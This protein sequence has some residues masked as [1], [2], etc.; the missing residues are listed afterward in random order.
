MA[1]IRLQSVTI[2]NLRS[3]FHE[4]FTLSDF[5]ALIGYNNAGKTNIL[6]ACRWLLS[7]YSLPINYFNDPGQPVE[8]E[9]I[10][11]GLAP[12][13]LDKMDPEQAN[14]LRPWLHN[15]RLII[16]KRQRI[17]GCPPEQ[18]EFCALRPSQYPVERE[19]VLR[20]KDLEPIIHQ[21]FPTPIQISDN[22][23]GEERD[24]R[25][26]IRTTVGKLIAEILKPLE[27]R[28]AE[29]IN[30]PLESMKDLLD[31]DGDE[32]AEELVEFD[33]QLNAKLEPLFP[34]VHIRLQIPAPNLHDIFQHA[35]LK[36]VEDV[37]GFIRD[38]DSLGTGTQR[39][40]QMALIRHLSE[41]R[42]KQH[43]PLSRTL[44]LIDS[45]ELFLH[46]QAVELVRSALKNLSREGF[47][48][49]FA[50]HSAQMV[51]SEDVSSSLLI[52]KSK[53]RGTFMRKRME[54][55]VRTVI[56]DA[57]SQLQML[58]SLSNSNEL[59]F[60]DYVLLTEGKTE[61]RILPYLFERVCGESFA[62]I[63][64][65]LVRQGGVS[66]TRKSMQVL[67][68]MDIPARAIVDLDYAFTGA[69]LDG[70]LDREDE[71]IEFCKNQ[72]RGLAIREHLR[73]VNGLPV[74][75]HSSVSAA[76]AYA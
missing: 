71:D 75:R 18:L 35:S 36:V 44:L 16:L 60:A 32:R 47:Q 13:L 2:S 17:P 21:L 31:M 28:Y 23:V 5:T 10:I 54:D 9:G 24:G 22:L 68:A 33:S 11:E 76:D 61:L 65:A 56:Q 19:W 38:V 1:H 57:P 40:I 46:P 37:D 49:I 20:P 50:T 45:P 64:C 34:S 42:K 41:V 27:R 51:T 26:L 70:F 59:L 74:T 30:N 53:Q 12:E 43:N 72:L 3:I 25:S 4:T 39:A 48:V 63:K 62:L 14:L 58:F 73:L 55:A 15:S 29:E 67:G 66:N 69:A 6:M 52:R 7:H 8:V